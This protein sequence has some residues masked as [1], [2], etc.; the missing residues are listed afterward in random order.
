MITSPYNDWLS[1]E[2]CAEKC[3]HVI[4]YCIDGVSVCKSVAVSLLNAPFLAILAIMLD[5]GRFFYEKAVSRLYVLR[6]I[7]LLPDPGVS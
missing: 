2:I 4:L 7:P 6:G 3:E 1:C 5:R